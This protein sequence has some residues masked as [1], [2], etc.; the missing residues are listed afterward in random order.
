[1]IV[2]E[3]LPFFKVDIPP[4]SRRGSVE[5]ALLLKQRTKRE[6]LPSPAIQLVRDGVVGGES[7]HDWLPGMTGELDVWEEHGRSGTLSEIM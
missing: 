6:N 5:E 3:P 1:M 2:C 7:D 4:G